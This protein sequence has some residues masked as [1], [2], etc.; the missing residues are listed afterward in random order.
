[1]S[2]TLD[3]ELKWD[4]KFICNILLNTSSS[5]VIIWMVFEVY[6]HF[7]VYG[8]DYKFFINIFFILLISISKWDFF[9]ILFFGFWITSIQILF[10]KD[11]FNINFVE[12]QKHNFK[13]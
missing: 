3:I 10:E 11:H 5:L 7:V 4:N 1:M 8:Y 12:V 9:T 13:K 6:L 2:K